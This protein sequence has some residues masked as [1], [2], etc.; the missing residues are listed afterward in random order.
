M[1]AEL[2]GIS[3]KLRGNGYE[4]YLEQGA[5]RSP[6][7]LRSLVTVPDEASNGL[8]V[9]GYLESKEFRPEA[10]RWSQHSFQV[11]LSTFNIY[12]ESSYPQKTLRAQSVVIRGNLNLKDV[13][14]ED[15]VPSRASLRHMYESLSFNELEKAF[16][17][18][19][20]NVGL[21]NMIKIRKKLSSC[22]D[23]RFLKQCNLLV[24]GE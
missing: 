19:A 18:Q 23:D 3:R 16:N 17:G 11:M 24:S 2:C 13:P 9:S 10:E 8:G 7:Q 20:V 6:D 21:I 14:L 12:A 4:T 5:S 22:C 1:W 15:F